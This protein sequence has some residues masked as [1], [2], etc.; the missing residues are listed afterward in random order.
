MGAAALAAATA[1]LLFL[2]GP[3]HGEAPPTGRLARFVPSG[4]QSAAMQFQTVSTRSFQTETVTD[5]Y[6][7]ANG[8]WTSSATAPVGRGMPVLQGQSA[9][10]IQAE[11]DLATARAQLVAARANEQRQHALYQADGAALKDWQQAQ[12]DAT[13]AA[14]ALSA[15]RNKL[16]VLGKSDQ[17]ILTLER[18][19]ADGAGRI[20]SIGD[21]SLVWLVANVREAD[22]AHVHLGD[23]AEVTLPAL[24]GKK[25]LATIAYKGEV[26]DT[27]THR[28]AVAALYKNSGHALSP[29]MLANFDILDRDSAVAPAVPR[30]AILYEGDQARL[31]V[32]GASGN[33]TVRFVKVGRIHDGYAEITNGLS[34]GERI[35]TGGA[36]FLD[37]ASTGG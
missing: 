10:M 2:L 27:A 31:W 34:A 14:S 5:G 22:A 13:T 17:D 28:L 37:Q 4:Q 16:R 11:G 33:F 6:V 32:V 3:G 30:N 20:F 25:L 36:L 12:V 19:S 8:G 21:T 35:V 26:I 24:G 18:K 29:N 23:Q 7:A 1:V 9:D 15:A